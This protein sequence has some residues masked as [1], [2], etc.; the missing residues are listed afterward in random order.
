MLHQLDELIDAVTTAYDNYSLL[1]AF[2]L[3]HDFCSVQVSTVYSTAMKD[4]LYC[5][6][7]DSS[8]RRRCQYVMFKVADALTRMLAPML[9]FTADEAWEYIPRPSGEE[10]TDS[11]HLAMLPVKRAHKPSK[12]TLEEWETLRAARDSAT[13]QLDELKKE[14][15]MNKPLDAEIVFSINDPSLRERISAYGDDLEDLVG[16]GYHK[17]VPGDGGSVRIE[18][19]DCRDIYKVC[20]RCWKRRPDVGQDAQYPDLSLR[21]AAVV[22]AAERSQ[23]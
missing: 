15:G 11:V 1:R 20:A 22:R 9:V 12:E 21:D 13:M 17:V 8:R 18:M 4:R 23:G 6:A 10:K 5:D 2:R 16:A 7:A 19:N 3:L 14:K